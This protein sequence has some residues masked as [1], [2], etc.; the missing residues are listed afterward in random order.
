[1]SPSLPTMSL[2][3]FR[4]SHRAARCLMAGLLLLGPAAVSAA[5]PAAPAEVLTKLHQSNG[6]EIAM[7]KLAQKNSQAK[8]NLD[9]LMRRYMDLKA[10]NP[11][12]YMNCSLV[13]KAHE[14]LVPML[15]DMFA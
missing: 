15:Q 10:K 3:A 7:G 9:E 2:V 13:N 11:D 6:R 12:D 4:W 5:D 1:M 8:G 14:E